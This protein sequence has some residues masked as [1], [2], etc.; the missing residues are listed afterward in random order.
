[1]QLAPILR[2]DSTWLA[3]QLLFGLLGGVVIGIALGASIVG[4]VW[5]LI[6]ISFIVLGALF[7]SNVETALVFFIFVNYIRLPHIIEVFHNGPPVTELF[8]LAFWGTI[9]FRM[10]INSAYPRGWVVP[11]VILTIHFCTTTVG[12]LYARDTGLVRREILF[13]AADAVIVL[14]IVVGIQDFQTFKQAIWGFIIGSLLLGLLGIYQFLTSTYTNDYWGFAVSDVSTIVDNVQDVRL[15]GPA[16]NGNFFA[17]MMV[18]VIP[19]SFERALHEESRLMRFLAAFALIIG[20]VTVILTFSRSGFIALAVVIVTFLI[21]YPPRLTQL[22]VML[23][24]FLLLLPFVPDSYIGRILTLGGIR[25]GIEGEAEIDNSSIRRYSYLVAGLEM[26]ED[27]PFLGIGAG[28]FPAAYVDYVR[29]TGI[30]SNRVQTT[31]S[32]HN[33][34]LEFLSE[35][36]IIGFAAFGLVLSTVIYSI[37]SS[38][39]YFLQVNALQQSHMITALGISVLGFLIFGLFLHL[40]NPRY[41][42]ILAGICWSA[43][44]IANNC[45]LSEDSQV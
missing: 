29:D 15:G 28:N 32:P 37:I 27:Y 6:G 12:L 30:V 14:A 39:Q 44:S 40:S 45:S 26:F 22:V 42:W 36:G 8:L 25:Q 21:L 16:G 9:A 24:A 10:V 33:L 23:I 2:R 38:R 41:F 18:I 19:L 11:L 13:F 17:Q 34:Y 4:S 3:A 7:L 31:R 5:I 43:T 1:M 20:I 35:R